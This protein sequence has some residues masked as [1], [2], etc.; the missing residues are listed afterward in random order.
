MGLDG[1]CFLG[2]LAWSEGL[3]SDGGGGGSFIWV[4]S[5]GLG[6]LGLVFWDV[7]PDS[8]STGYLSV[9]TQHFHLGKL[10]SKCRC[11]PDVPSFSSIF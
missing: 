6:Y 3:G 10:G 8:R 11:H 1:G 4:R 2:F 7:Q 9:S 5:L